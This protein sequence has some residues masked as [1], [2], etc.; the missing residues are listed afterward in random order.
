MR[1]VTAV[2]VLLVGAASALSGQHAH[3]LE[4]GGFGTYTWYDKAFQLDNQFGGGGRVGFFLGNALGLELEGTLGY[5][6]PTAGGKHTQMR[7]G[8]A[9]LV[10]NSGGDRNILYLLGGYSRM[11]NGVNAPYNFVLNGFHAGIGDRIFITDRFALR[12][13]ARG[14]YSRDSAFGKSSITHILGSAG[15]SYFFFGGPPA[16]KAPE[17]P[18]ARRDSIVAAGGKVPER[19]RAQPGGGGGG[20]RGRRVSYEQTGGD[21]AHKW[22][23]GGQGG[24]MSVRTNLESISFQPTVGGHWLITGTQTAMYVGYDQA[25]FISPQQWF[26]LASSNLGGTFKFDGV[27]RIMAGMVAF[28]LR[29]RIEP[30]GG[31]GFA[32]MQA[33]GIETSSAGS[34]LGCTSSSDSSVVLAA[35]NNE[36][37]RAF[38]WI[39]GGIDI[40][41]GRLALFGHY[42]LTSSSG[43]FAIQGSTHTIQG[44]IRYSLGSAKEV[45]TEGH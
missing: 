13:E 7:W 27:R 12:L 37:T 36:G 28:P 32:I 30:F 35:A 17:I 45:L 43:N 1:A 6:N 16:E 33:R 25:V 44:G 39:M 42:I 8:S 21:W 23:W 26:V 38:V 31:G 3:Q 10:L 19:P 29:Q 15:F 2:G 40:N 4:L 24:I 14:Y 9:S 41:Q 22:F 20:G 34:C 18:K 11:D 5:P